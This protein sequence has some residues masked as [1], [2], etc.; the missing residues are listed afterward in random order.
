MASPTWRR[1][2]EADYLRRDERANSE[3][4][5]REAFKQFSLRQKKLVSSLQKHFHSNMCFFTLSA[6]NFPSWHH[7]LETNIASL[8]F[9]YDFN[10]QYMR[11]YIC[12]DETLIIFEG[13]LDCCSSTQQIRSG[14]RITEQME[15]IMN[16]SNMHYL[17]LVCLKYK[18]SECFN[19][20]PTKI[21]ITFCFILSNSPIL[22]NN[23]HPPTI[24]RCFNHYALGR[25]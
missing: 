7:S 6:S 21:K 4:E 25:K 16:T 1:E 2:G 15:G 20:G 22:S 13:K 8:L 23:R 9:K 12:L 24:L 3:K 19:D 5:Q 18:N 14:N 10:M 17:I 11:N